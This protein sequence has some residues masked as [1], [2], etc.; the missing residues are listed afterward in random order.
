MVTVP[1]ITPAPRRLCLEGTGGLSLVAD[2]Y[3]PEQAPAV[4]LLHGFGQTRRAWRATAH[5]LA[6]AGYRVVAP[7]ARGHGE[8]GHARD[9]DYWLDDFVDDARRFCRH[10][11]GPVLVGASMGGLTGLLAEAE[12][13]RRLVAGLVLVDIAPRWETSGVE[14]ILAFMKARPEGF[15]SLD[16]AA[17]SVAEYLPQR[18]PRKTVEGLE[19]YLRETDDGRL[20]WHWD[21][22]LLAQF[23]AEPAPYHQ[24]LM[25]AAG[26]LTCPTLLVSGELS[27]VVSDEGITEFLQAVP[28]ARHDSIPGAAHMVAGDQNDAFTESVRRFIAALDH[29]SNGSTQGGP[30]S[31]A[32]WS[33]RYSA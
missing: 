6:R 3:G 24:R 11:G 18:E 4:L 14:R 33:G 23:G 25:A 16:D 22:N 30:E 26:L 19:P 5:E 27:E 28:H 10:L 15:K 31:A 2:D 17:R 9:G 8:S 1:H 12:N 7:D 29:S 20:V 21:P 32:P 13:R